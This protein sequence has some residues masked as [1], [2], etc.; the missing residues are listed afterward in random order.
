M[1][2]LEKMMRKLR[3][4]GFGDHWRADKGMYEEIKDEEYIRKRAEDYYEEWLRL[5]NPDSIKYKYPNNP[6]DH[7]KFMWIEGYLMA[8]KM[9]SYERYVSHRKVR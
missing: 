5:S 3:Q 8:N 1:T 2:P 4:A 7:E 6:N 9:G